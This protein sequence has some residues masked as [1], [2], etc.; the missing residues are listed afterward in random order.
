MSGVFDCALESISD[1][2][3]FSEFSY[4]S[5][6]KIS[7]AI[8]S[9]V[10]YCYKTRGTMSLQSLLEITAM[11]SYFSSSVYFVGFFASLS[12]GQ[13]A[14]GAQQALK[15][16]TLTSSESG[17]LVNSHLIL[18]Q[19]KAVLIDAQF[20]NSDAQ[21]VVDAIK[22]SGK[23]LETIFITH[24]HP[25]HYFGLSVIS[26]AFP[27]AKV[28][29]TADVLEDMKSTAE[30]KFGYWKPIYKTNLTDKVIFP[31]VS[32]QKFIDLE[33][34]NIEI[35]SVVGAESHAQNT[36]FVKS[37]NA[38]IAGDLLYSQVHLWLAEGRSSAWKVTLE[39]LM[40]QTTAATKVYPGHGA[41]GGQELIEQNIGYIKA[42]EESLKL[43]NA[44]DAKVQM[45]AKY[46]NYA[47]P[48][49]LDIAVDA[50]FAAKA[51]K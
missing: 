32:N 12:I 9:Q 3:I 19:K 5:T 23:E 48:V 43:P 36:L 20:T 6:T 37:A 38:L 30:G 17:F 34:E 29:A 27:K 8:S 24:G 11:L 2:D 1:R 13:I 10:G 42:F 18:G 50:G 33:G 25:D 22:K 7:L 15:V 21:M 44:A 51:K 49:I 4:L 45:K 31:V 40:L 39:K 46:P 14:F 47:L 35:S 26:K 41:A 16:E 28:I